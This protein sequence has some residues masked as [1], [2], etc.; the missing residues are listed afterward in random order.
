MKLGKA[1]FGAIFLL[2]GSILLIIFVGDSLY[3]R[4]FYSIIGIIVFSFI[5]SR[6]A[7]HGISLRRS[8]RNHRLPVGSLLEERYEIENRSP[9]IK[10]WV[11]IVDRSNLSHSAGSRILTFIGPHNSRN[12]VCFTR[13]AQR[14]TFLL[15]PITIKS[16]DIFG[17]FLIEKTIQTGEKVIVTPYIFQIDQGFEPYGLLPGGKVKKNKS[18][19]ASPY[20]SGIREYQPG[21]P[22]NHIH[23]RFSSK[24]G[25]LMVKEFDQDPQ[26][27]VWIMIDASAGSQY[28][29][30][31]LKVNDL[32]SHWAYLKKSFSYEPESSMDYLTSLG[33]SYSKY[34][35][36][37]GMALGLICNDGSDL[38]IPAERGERQFIKI[39]D[40]LSMLKGSGKQSILEQISF[41]SGYLH[42]GSLVIILTSSPESDTI[43]G[44]L[45]LQNRGFQ[46]VV[47]LIDPINLGYETKIQEVRDKLISNEIDCILINKIEYIQEIKDL[48]NESIYSNNVK[49]VLE[50]N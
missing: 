10:F 41:E 13:L 32:D 22:L 50:T 2:V 48:L 3:Y 4:I 11:E 28:K 29:N 8:S 30:Q 14:G 25:E 26:A 7:L 45:Q 21:D 19:L 35:I 37:K 16:G 38:I 40:V 31:L 18:A 36:D 47:V 23:W 15:S 1:S 9:I 33:A 46:V 20:S 5:T 39:L 34:Y 6:F 44:V 24:H 27:D 42:R 17:I 12:Y 49:W 43:Q